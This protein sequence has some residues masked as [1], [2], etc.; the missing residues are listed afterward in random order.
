WGVPAEK[1][2]EFDW[3]DA[4]TI[5]DI[6]VTFTPTRHFSGR[7]LRDR[8]KSLWGGWVFRT[9][10]ERIWF[11]GDGGYGGHF[12][13]IGER[14]GPFDFALM[15]C[16]QYNDYWRYIHLFPE[17]SIQ[18]ALDAKV[19]KVMP[20]HWAGFS[21]SFQHTWSQPAQDFARHA[22]AHQLAVSFPK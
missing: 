15:E 17:E 3:W 6:E 18:A 2:T 12:K 10:Q 9:G 4:V 7:G 1:I 14:L 13:E 19:S 5:N 21:L 11:S 16:G 20:V 22:A 8:F